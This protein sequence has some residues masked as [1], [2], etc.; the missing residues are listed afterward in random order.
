MSRKPKMYRRLVSRAIVSGQSQLTGLRWQHYN[1]RKCGQ[2]W[3]PGGGHRLHGFALYNGPSSPIP[4]VELLLGG[5]GLAC[6]SSWCIQ[7]I[8]PFTGAPVYGGRCVACLVQRWVQAAKMAICVVQAQSTASFQSVLSGN[9]PSPGAPIGVTRCFHQQA[10]FVS[11]VGDPKREAFSL[12]VCGFPRGTSNSWAI[13]N[14]LN[15]SQQK[16]SKFHQGLLAG[17]VRTALNF[18]YQAEW[19]HLFSVPCSW[20]ATTRCPPRAPCNST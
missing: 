7:N 13:G 6:S 15:K 3:A 11:M 1:L 20:I 17:A 8:E 16:Y 14:S 4:T 2:Q 18:A 19:S 5:A 12:P 10:W 9:G